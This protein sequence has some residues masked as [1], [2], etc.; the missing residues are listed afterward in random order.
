MKRN[1]I[2]LLALLLA[3]LTPV[4]AQNR[5]GPRGRDAMGPD[6]F[7]IRFFCSTR[8][9]QRPMGSVDAYIR[10]AN[11]ALS[12]LKQDSS[13]WQ[14][15]YDLE[16]MI[17]GGSRELAAYKILRDTVTVSRFELTNSRINP[18]THAMH[19][20]LKPGDYTWRLKLLNAEQLPLIERED[21][22][23]VPD[24]GLD[25]L[26]ISDILLADSLDCSAG[27]YALNL[28]GV[29][30]RNSGAVGVIYEL[31][32]PAGADS[33][34]TQLTLSDLSGRKMMEQRES[35][36]AEPVLHGCIDL[37]KEITKPGE[38]LL[39]I[40]ASAGSRSLQT[41]QRLFL[42]WGH[43]AGPGLSN[44]AAVEQLALIAKGSTIREILRAQGEER[45]KLVDAFWAQRDPT[46]GTPEN[47]LKDEFYLR[48]DFAN[49]QFGEPVSGR[50]GWRTDRGRVFIQNGTPDQIEKQGGEMGMAS[51]EIWSY[52][53]L[54]R[55]YLFVD[56]MNNGEFRL[57]KTE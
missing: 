25:Q 32:P 11:D 57:L 28:R 18:R 17:Y 40:R 38:Y 31:Y 29:F 42:L 21:R 54:N 15:R 26:Q 35:R 8:P 14:A 4:F 7:Q 13:S 16:L 9:E 48:L 44:E 50:P 1:P 56:R 24:F 36:P 55:R 43:A 52:N 34:R 12:F 19:F 33:V 53:R 23:K 20:N 47:E 46:P 22:L 39:Q 37:G 3:T 2:C 51:A 49:Q 27:L 30:S 45:E 6:I 5:P 41:S 10:I